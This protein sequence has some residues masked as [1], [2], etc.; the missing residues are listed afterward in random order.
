MEDGVR[1]F[2]DAPRRMDEEGLRGMFWG[3]GGIDAVKFVLALEAVSD[4]LGTK[5]SG[6][7]GV[8]AGGAEAGAPI[9]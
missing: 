6:V 4:R 2:V 7:L 8:M 1:R 9:T 5:R 3:K